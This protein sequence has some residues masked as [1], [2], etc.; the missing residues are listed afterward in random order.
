MGLINIGNLRAIPNTH[1]SIAVMG[2]AI[3]DKLMG[4][5]GGEPWRGLQGVQ[6]LMG[7]DRAA[8]GTCAV[9][10]GQTRGNLQV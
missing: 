6:K 3:A 2:Y 4:I 10:T 7:A 9:V 8:C 5:D 1:V